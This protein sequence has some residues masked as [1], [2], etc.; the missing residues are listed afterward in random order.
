M[1]ELR[2]DARETSVCISYTY[3]S[4]A[5]IQAE[6]AFRELNPALG[7]VRSIPGH[8]AAPDNKGGRGRAGVRGQGVGM[9]DKAGQLPD[10]A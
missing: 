7:I 3:A 1:R 6:L 2:Y 5:R 4:S 8:D 10:D 9:V